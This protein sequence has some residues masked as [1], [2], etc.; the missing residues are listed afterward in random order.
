MKKLFLFII[1]I[2]FNFKQ[3]SQENIEGKILFTEDGK[4]YPVMGA[5]IKWINT[6]KGTISNDQGSFK[7]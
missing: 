4:D 2:C 1:L 6:D 7:L 5:S 3:F